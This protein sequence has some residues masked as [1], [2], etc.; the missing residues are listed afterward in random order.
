MTPGT[1][2]TSF[3]QVNHLCP[4]L[5]TLELLPLLL[6]TAAASGDGRI[7]FVSSQGHFSANPFNPDALS[8]VG[9]ALFNKGYCNSKLYNVSELALKCFLECDSE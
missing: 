1:L 5:L 3:I 8:E 4:L 7:I 2:A 6:H 9:T